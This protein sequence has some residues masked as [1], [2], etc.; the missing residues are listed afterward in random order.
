MNG[1]WWCI[2]ELLVVVAGRVCGRG[3]RTKARGVCQ[4][5]CHSSCWVGGGMDHS[6]RSFG[7]GTG[8]GVDWPMQ[9]VLGDG[10]W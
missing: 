5:V 10:F 2:L 6:G 9:T 3:L 7:R 1:W 8:W 4:I